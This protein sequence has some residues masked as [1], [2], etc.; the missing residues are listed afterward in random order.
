MTTKPTPVKLPRKMSALITLALADLAKCER[1]EKYA[2]Y[3]GWWHDRWTETSPCTVC[4][5]GAV[6][7]QS[8]GIGSHITG[9]EKGLAPVDFPGNGDQLYALNSLRSGLVG[10]AAEKL[11]LSPTERATAWSLERVPCEHSDDPKQFRADMR[12]LARELEAVGL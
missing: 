3:M 9:W 7:A 10:A 12:K 2:V 6:M 4:F 5:A 11:G 1:S 8:L